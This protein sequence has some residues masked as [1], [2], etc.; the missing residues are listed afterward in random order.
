MLWNGDPSDSGML[1]PQVPGTQVTHSKGCPCWAK[2]KCAGAGPGS[3]GARE[4]GAGRPPLGGLGLTLGV[5]GQPQEVLRM[6][7][8]GN[9][10]FSALLPTQ[11]GPPRHGLCRSLHRKW[12]AART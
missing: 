1:T 12:A 10:D 6:H 4:V 11:Q 3:G 7:P 9:S 5:R 2:S 8:A